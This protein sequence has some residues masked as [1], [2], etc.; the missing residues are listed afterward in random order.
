MGLNLYPV[1]RNLLFKLDA[2]KAHNFSLKSL[3]LVDQFKLSNLF[4][5]KKKLLSTRV[6]GIDF[7]NPV[8]LAAGLDKNGDYYSAL[9]SCGF[10]FVEIG[11]VTPLP[12][13]GNPLPR[14]FR[15]P[16]AEAII[17]RMGFNNLG[18][19]YLVERVKKQIIRVCWVL[20]LV[21]IKTRQKKKQSMII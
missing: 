8:G 7:P 21:K 10:G 14:L 9:S 17:N 13:P 18:V 11:T 2:E 3:K 6:M 4:F 1:L 12:Q 5:G 15:L 19:D 16:E 20:I